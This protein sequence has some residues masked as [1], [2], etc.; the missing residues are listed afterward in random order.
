VRAVPPLCS[1]TQQAQPRPA[2]ARRRR[3][4]AEKRWKRRFCRTFL[5]FATETS[6]SLGIPIV[7]VPGANVQAGGAVFEI[8]DR[9]P[10]GKIGLFRFLGI[11]LGVGIPKLGP[12]SGAGLGTFTDFSTTDPVGLRD[13]DGDASFGQPPE[14]GPLGNSL[15]AIQSGTF[16]LKEAH[17]VPDP[18]PINSFTVIANIFAP[19]QVASP[20]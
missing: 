8:V 10:G 12:V 20:Y 13:F 18:L 2:S 14:L 9:S 19:L 11:G 5:P 6:L 16:F 1:G 4:A 17:T 3:G 15:L 7:I